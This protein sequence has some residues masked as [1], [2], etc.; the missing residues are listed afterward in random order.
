MLPFH[1][2]HETIECCR[3][4]PDHRPTLRCRLRRKLSS[5]SSSQAGVFCS[6]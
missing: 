2:R 6:Q 4:R 1:N 3:Q 5:W